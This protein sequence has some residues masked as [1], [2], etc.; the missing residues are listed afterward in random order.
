MLLSDALI[1]KLF[2]P[3][4]EPVRNMSEKNR[5][6]DSRFFFFILLLSFIGFFYNFMYQSVFF[7]L[8]LEIKIIYG[9]ELGP[10]YYSYI[11]MI[12]AL[13]VIMLTSLITMLTSKK[14][15]IMN[16][17][18]AMML[19]SLG[20]FLFFFSYNMPFFA[21]SMIIWTSG[22]ILMATNI[23][24]YLNNN[25]PDRSRGFFNSVYLGLESLG[26]AAAPAAAGLVLS[27][28]GYNPVWIFLSLLSLLIA[29][30]YYMLGNHYV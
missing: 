14:R 4:I 6:N 1:I 30:S 12:N 15:P 26:G 29:F 11:S 28:S 21:F 3:Y 23:N 24:A 20:L 25:V 16:I 2:V 7:V 8:P 18:A 19:Y 27:F 13:S 5:K 9:D 22:E 17:V 10:S